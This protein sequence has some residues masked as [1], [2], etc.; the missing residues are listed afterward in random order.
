MKMILIMIIWGVKVKKI[1]L[2]EERE[3]RI[4]EERRIK[5]KREGQLKEEGNH[6]LKYNKITEYIH[7]EL[8]YFY[9]T[10]ITRNPINTA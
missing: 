4:K 7:H 10:K 1:R 9:Q 8:N 3:S 6:V 2:K 5:R